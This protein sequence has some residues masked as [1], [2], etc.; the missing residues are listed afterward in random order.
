MNKIIRKKNIYEVNEITCCTC[1]T[2]I[3]EILVHKQGI[4][5]L[6]LMSMDPK[7][8]SHDIFR[9]NFFEAGLG[10]PKILLVIHSSCKILTQM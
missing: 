2:I 1:P 9:Y 6:I 8:W 10:S 5:T 7:G 3:S 4:V